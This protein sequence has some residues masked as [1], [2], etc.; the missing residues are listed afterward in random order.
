MPDELGA[1]GIEMLRETL[2]R[3]SRVAAL[4][5]GDNPGALI[6]VTETE[7]R[8]AQLDLQFLSTSAFRAA[9]HSRCLLDRSPRAN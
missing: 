6:V 2:P 4:Y 1:K 3:I 9:W 8:S 7:R 5:Q